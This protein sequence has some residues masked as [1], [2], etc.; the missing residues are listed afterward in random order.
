[1]S[2]K[3]AVLFL[4]KQSFSASMQH[5]LITETGIADVPRN[6][7]GAEHFVVLDG[8]RGIAALLVGVMHASQLLIRP[9]DYA[10]LS[11]AVDF[12][13]CLSGFVIAFAYEERLKAGMNMSEFSARRIIRLYPMI[14][15]GSLLGGAVFFIGSMREGGSQIQ[16][17]IF[18]LTSLLLLPGGLFFAGKEA[19]PV[20]NPIWSL[21]FEVIANFIYAARA[22]VST[23]ALGIA[24]AVS[25]LALGSMS[26]FG[27]GIEEFGFAGPQYFLGGFI[28]VAYPFIAGLLLYRFLG[29]FRF[30]IHPVF[31]V[32]ALVATLVAP[33]PS[34]W[35]YDVFAVVVAFPAIVWMATLSIGGS[36]KIPLIVLGEISYPFYL[37]HQPM[38]RV[39]KHIDVFTRFASE[40]PVL[41]VALS[42]IAISIAA[43]VTFWVYDQRL[44]Q[45]FGAYIFR[46]R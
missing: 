46:G 27:N 15:L 21:F 12:F 41:S 30:R 34:S 29:A 37:V 35:G 23:S 33:V 4:S 14:F 42:L 22:T 1:M 8:L 45:L 10:H 2:F 26:Y 16:A 28:R 9:A 19:Y 25:A 17:I 13:F 3:F 5:K 6:S 7:S 39:L 36:F 43:Y 24:A 20:N 32:A 40:Y 11:L 18:T 44:R 31:P 38:L